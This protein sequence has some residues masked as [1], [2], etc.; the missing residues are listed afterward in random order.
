MPPGADTLLSQFL[1][2]ICLLLEYHPL[3][4]TSTI[5]VFHREEIHFQRPESARNR[6]FSKA[7]DWHHTADHF[8]PREEH[9]YVAVDFERGEGSEGLREE[10]KPRRLMERRT[11]PAWG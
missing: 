3:H 7:R 4:S 11:R 8:R 9:G 10:T 2:L 6:S 5:Q 1:H